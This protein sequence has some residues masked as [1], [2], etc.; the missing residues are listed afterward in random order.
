MKINGA[1]FISEKEKKSCIHDNIYQRISNY[2]KIRHSLY[3]KKKDLVK[4]IPTKR[5]P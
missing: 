3:S 2:A 4:D 1:E 5:K